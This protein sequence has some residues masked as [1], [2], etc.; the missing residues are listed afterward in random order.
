MDWSQYFQGARSGSGSGGS[1]GASASSSARS[2]ATQRLG[3]NGDSPDTTNNLV[4]IIGGLV[5]LL[6]VGGLLY[7]AF[8]LT[9]KGK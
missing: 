7:A 2:S 9:R 8:R 1:G 4:L 5:G 3:N 6:I